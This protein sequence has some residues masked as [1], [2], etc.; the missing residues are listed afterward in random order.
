MHPHALQLIVGVGLTQALLLNPTRGQQVRV[1]R[2]LKFK[3]RLRRRSNPFRRG[4]A[5]LQ[6]FRRPLKLKFRLQRRL[7]S[8]WIKKDLHVPQRRTRPV[9]QLDAETASARAILKFE[10][11]TAQP[12]GKPAGVLE[13]AG[14]DVL[15]R[16]RRADLV[17]IK[18]DPV[19]VV[20]TALH[21]CI[22][23][24]WNLDITRGIANEI[25]L[26]RRKLLVAESDNPLLGMKDPPGRIE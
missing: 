2:P 11:Q 1:P 9:G 4:L 19:I 5:L 18:K 7:A 23:I 22:S 21:Q 24:L 13:V 16:L 8:A 6:L 12:L 3:V 10:K 20:R 26:N 15:T 17:E 14:Q 25:I